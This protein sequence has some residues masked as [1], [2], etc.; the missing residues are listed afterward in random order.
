M[1]SAVN[2]HLTQLYLKRS[3]DWVNPVN[4]GCYTEYKFHPLTGAK[5]ELEQDALHA[6]EP[7]CGG[8]RRSPRP[9]RWSSAAATGGQRAAEYPAAA[10]T[11]A[12]TAAAATGDA[13]AADAAHDEPAAGRRRS[14]ADESQPAA[15]AGQSHAA[16]RRAG[17]TRHWTTASHAQHAERSHDAA[18]PA[19]QHVA[20]RLHAGRNGE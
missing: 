20:R 13:A 14:T 11:T 3:Y 12:A 7:V 10:A 2:P 17:R 19:A 6:D 16:A 9:R 15:A 4:S 18:E 8:G 5:P 1:R